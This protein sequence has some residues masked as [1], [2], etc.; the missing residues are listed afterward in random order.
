MYEEINNEEQVFTVTDTTALSATH[1]GASCMPV[2][3]SNPGM[4]R[5]VLY[6][7]GWKETT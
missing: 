5:C 1:I 4:K 6:S 3:T 2:G 7:Y